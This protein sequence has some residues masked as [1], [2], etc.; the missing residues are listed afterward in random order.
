MPNHFNI[1]DKANA[2]I[3]ANIEYT[4][5]TPQNVWKNFGGSWARA[6]FTK[7]A[8]GVVHL[9]GLITDGIVALGTVIFNLPVGYRPSEDRVF[10]VLTY[11]GIIV[12]HGRVDVRVNGDV[13]TGLQDNN[14][15][16]TW[17]TLEGIL[18]VAAPV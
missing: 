14:L 5:I 12:K 11:N 10:P 16:S 15:S 9:K 6:G 2:N 7:D 4:D 8:Q 1:L 3:E 13:T 17:V 18:F